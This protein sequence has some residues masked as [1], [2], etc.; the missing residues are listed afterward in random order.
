MFDVELGYIDDHHDVMD[1]QESSLRYT[2]ERLSVTASKEFDQLDV[3]PSL[4]SEDFPRITFEEARQILDEEYGHV[5]DD[6]SDL[7]TRGE[8]LIGEYFEDRG[9]PAVFVMGYP[10]AKF[11]YRQD[12]PGDEIASRKFDILYRGLELSSGGQREHDVDRL[13]SALEQ[14]G[15][16]PS[17]LEFYLEAFRYGVPPHGGYGLGVDRLVQQLAGLD[18]IKEAIMFPRDPDRLTP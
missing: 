3:S 8:R 7:D 4:P 11:Y 14:Q 15:I 18:N 2:I 13:H 16:D 12:V 5:P 17:T 6:P 10:E 1:V 9:H